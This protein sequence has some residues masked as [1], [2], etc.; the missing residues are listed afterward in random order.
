V[1][2]K[3]KER[4]LGDLRYFARSPDIYPSSEGYHHSR[5]KIRDFLRSLDVIEI[6]LKVHGA[7][8]S[9]TVR[10]ICMIESEKRVS[11]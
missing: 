2:K 4:L 7:S 3:G 6:A 11:I 8:I 1:Q 9:L 10:I 5:S